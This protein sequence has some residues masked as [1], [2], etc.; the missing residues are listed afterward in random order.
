MVDIAVDILRDQFIDGMHPKYDAYWQFIKDSLVG[1]V[2]CRD[3][4]I[5]MRKSQG[6]TSGHSH[7]TLVQSIITLIVGYMTLFYHKPDL[8][9]E[10]VLSDVHLISLGDDNL[11]SLT[12]LFSELTLE[13]ITTAADEGCGIDWTG[14]KSFET[15]RVL[16]SVTD[17]FQGIQYLGKYLRLEV[18]ES[19]EGE[20]PVVIPYR[21]FAETLERMYHP[22]RSVLDLNQ[23]Y[24]RALG[25]YY[26]A[27]GNPT[28]EKWLNELLDWME[29]QGAVAPEE[30]SDD[31][32]VQITKDYHGLGFV[33]PPACRINYYA[34]LLWLTS[35]DN[36]QRYQRRT[37]VVHAPP[38]PETG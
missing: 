4:G 12:D 28:T 35:D 13:D 18:F 11:M 7:N 6:T 34:W 14:R 16:D 32:G 20:I 31:V 21:P 30:F 17:E 9:D 8:S 27:A 29:E 26:D 19:E 3:D 36:I 1:V 37:S 15:T 23:S 33:V 5:R 25:N 38:P 22:E 10:E 24:E 2:I